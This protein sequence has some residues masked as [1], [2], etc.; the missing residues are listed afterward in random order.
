MKMNGI[1][2]GG[3]VVLISKRCEWGRVLVCWFSFECILIKEL[4]IGL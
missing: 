3:E 2:L 4:L 1:K